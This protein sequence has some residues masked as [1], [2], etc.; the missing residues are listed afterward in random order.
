MIGK[1]V[2]AEELTESRS[3]RQAAAN[4]TDDGMRIAED[5]G[6][7]AVEQSTEC[8]PETEVV[9]EAQTDSDS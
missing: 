9:Q 2:D 7:K 3:S 1:Q 4:A 5:D 8:S 6:E